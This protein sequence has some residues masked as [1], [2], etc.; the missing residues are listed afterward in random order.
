MPATQTNTS[1]A[2]FQLHCCVLLW[3]FTGILGKLISLP[4]VPL[5]WWRVLIVALALLLLPHT[6]RGLRQLPWRMLS[7]Y[8]GI[9][10]VVALHWLCF[11]GSVK[12]ANASVAASTLALA[13][14]FIAFVE[15][16]LMRQRMKRAELLLGLAIVPGVALVVGGTPQRMYPG[17]VLGVLSALFVALFGS[18]NKRYVMHTNALTMT[19]LEMSGAVLFITAS[20]LIIGTGIIG[21]GPLLPSN[22]A[23]F[24][25]PTTHDAVLLLIL[26]LGC[27]LLPFALALKAMRQLSAF[28]TQL[29]VNL[30]PVYTIIL[31]ML[32]F[33]EQRELTLRFFIGVLIVLITVFAYPL[34]HRSAAV[35][36]QLID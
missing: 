32:W 18:F 7:I 8:L 10:L 4:A 11:Y 34:L 2:W 25:L 5:V 16:W 22:E 6:W 28:G 31:G 13:P 15:P 36:P 26:S 21:T 12:L 20:M 3:G 9:G 24:V 33:G 14:V 29:A 1:L 19:C 35:A 27:T 23:G 17:L 30:E